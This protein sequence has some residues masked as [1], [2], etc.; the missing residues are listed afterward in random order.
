[1]AVALRYAA[2]LPASGDLMQLDQLK[3]REF[4]S[5]LGGCAVAGWPLGAARIR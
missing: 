4:M 3:R 5:L 2:K 1:M